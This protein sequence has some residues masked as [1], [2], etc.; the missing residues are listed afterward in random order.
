MRGIQS[1]QKL[2]F[3]KEICCRHI[4]D[5]GELS[6]SQDISPF[7]VKGCQYTKEKRVEINYTK[8]VMIV[9]AD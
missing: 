9:L 3:V 7:N 4:Q 2:C 8:R 1:V 6:M 5:F